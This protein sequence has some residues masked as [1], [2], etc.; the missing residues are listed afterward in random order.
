MCKLWIARGLLPVLLGFGALVWVSLQSTV[1]AEVKEE[2]FVS[3]FNG[4]DLTGWEGKPGLWRVGDGMLVG[5]SPGIQHNHFLATGR[6]YEDF[7][8]KL[9]FRLVN[10][11]GNSGVQFRSRRVPDSEAVSGYQA[12]IGEQYW[13]SLYDESRRRRILVDARKAGVDAV[14]N[15]KGW[16]DLVI[17]CRGNQVTIELN[18]LKTVDYREPDPEIARSG[19]IALQVHSGGPMEIQFKDI[20]IKELGK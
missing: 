4:K 5:D 19:I 20:R 15:E 10:G 18:G 8:L 2:G 1:L 3:L 7:I 17:R 14:V 13:G 16:N 11:V 12:D 6:V 9:S